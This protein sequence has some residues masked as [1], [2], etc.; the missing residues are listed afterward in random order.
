M[1]GR[2][3][4]QPRKRE[5]RK[6]KPRKREPRKSGPAARRMLRRCK[7]GSSAA[8]GEIH[9]DNTESVTDGCV[10]SAGDGTPD[11]DLQIMLAVTSLGR[12]PSEKH[13][14]S[15][16]DKTESRLGRNIRNLK[17][18][19]KLQTATLRFLEEWR[20]ASET[21]VEVTPKRKRLRQKT[22]PLDDE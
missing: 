2:R 10:C 12:Y 16:D 8:G 11:R 4:K 7:K 1:G 19:N 18:K 21:D 6:R 17:R 3:A 20:R 13:P 9:A 5:P 14:Q 22:S 15:R